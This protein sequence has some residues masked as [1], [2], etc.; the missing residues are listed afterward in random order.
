MYHPHRS[1]PVI[2]IAFVLAILSAVGLSRNE[3]LPISV[4]SAMLHV[5]VARTEAEQRQGLSGR[6]SLGSSDGMLFLFPADGRHGMWMPN[7]NLS[8]D[9]IWLDADKRVVHIERNVSP[10]SYPDC[11]FVTGAVPIRP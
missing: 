4:G 5:D 11:L 9:L 2:C 3:L 1:L 7:M 8:L 10:D 6:S